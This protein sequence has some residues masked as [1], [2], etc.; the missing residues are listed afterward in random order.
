MEETE[1]K[2]DSW[3][4]IS[5]SSF[6]IPNA[7]PT[8]PLAYIKSQTSTLTDRKCNVYKKDHRHRG[9][10]IVICIALCEPHGM[11]ADFRV[12]ASGSLWGWLEEEGI[13]DSTRKKK[14]DT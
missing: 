6:F 3:G 13:S 11:S 7:K 14:R 5:I 2:A 4:K 9:L 12:L 8:K 1:Q 10:K